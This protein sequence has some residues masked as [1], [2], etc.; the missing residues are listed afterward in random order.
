[1]ERGADVSVKNDKGDTPLCVLARRNPCSD[2][3]VFADIAKLLLSN[4]AKVPRSGKE[5]TALIEAVRNRHF[6]MADVMLMSGGRMD[7]SD[8]NGDNVLHMLCRCAGLI[9]SDIKSRER[10][11][12]D[13]AERWYSDKS[14]QET[15]DELESLQESDRQCSHTARLIL[16]SGQIDPEEKN[17]SGRFL[18]ILQQKGVP[19]ESGHCCRGRIP[20]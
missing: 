13:F 7:S 4:G 11:I 19:D 9:A 3:A 20:K 18:L 10:R 17:H 12:A 16:E 14:K 2:D 8:R 1:M 6:L 5:T 15:Y